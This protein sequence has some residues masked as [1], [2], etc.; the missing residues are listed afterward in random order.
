MERWNSLST[1]INSESIYMVW[2]RHIVPV[3]V[4]NRKIYLLHFWKPK[5]WS[6]E[7]VALLQQRRAR[8]SC[9][10]SG[11]LGRPDGSRPTGDLA[12]RYLYRHPRQPQAHPSNEHVEVLRQVWKPALLFR[13]VVQ[14]CRAAILSRRI[15]LTRLECF[16]INRSA[17]TVQTC[18][19]EM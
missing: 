16:Q 6:Q 8:S 11:L 19:S 2:Y 3:W 18:S 1:A 5:W 13:N 4:S 7:G 9:Q 12:L 14:K 15:T 10:G 17:S